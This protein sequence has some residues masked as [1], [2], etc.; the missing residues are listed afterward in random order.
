MH[1]K[2]IQVSR[3]PLCREDYVGEWQF[4][5]SGFCP[6]IADYVDEYLCD[7]MRE[8]IIKDFLNQF[9]DNAIVVKPHGNY[10]HGVIFSI[11]EGFLA[12]FRDKCLQGFKEDVANS[13]S[14]SDI[15]YAIAN[16]LEDEF[17][18]YI[19]EEGVGL[20]PVRRW[21]TGWASEDTI[22]YIGGVIDYHW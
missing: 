12:S 16:H 10:A 19:Y 8:Y 4:I 15:R 20:C 6:W 18:T 3:I 13:N 21:L 7:D 1:S 14:L 5:D 9:G 2:I 11:T 17:S 22:Y